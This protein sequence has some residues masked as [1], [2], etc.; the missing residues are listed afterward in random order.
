MTLWL[1]L[2]KDIYL[3]STWWVPKWL[4]WK[5]RETL[6]WDTAAFLISSTTA[7]KAICGDGRSRYLHTQVNGRCRWTA[8]NLP[9]VLSFMEAHYLEADDGSATVA[10]QLYSCQPV[11]QVQGENIKMSQ[12]LM[13]IC[14]FFFLFFQIWRFVIREQTLQIEDWPQQPGDVIATKMWWLN[15]LDQVIPHFAEAVDN[16]L[17]LSLRGLCEYTCLVVRK[18]TK[19]SAM[20]INSK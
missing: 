10:A 3:S 7:G 4:A 14:W 13:V 5:Y 18:A 11:S 2:K 17:A 12:L 19:G 15:L 9:S 20:E 8:I 6:K 16:C 1:F